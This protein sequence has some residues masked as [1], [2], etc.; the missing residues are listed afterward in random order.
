MPKEI[1]WTLN[2]VPNVVLAQTILYF[3]DKLHELSE[4][5]LLILRGRLSQQS[6]T[7]RGRVALMIVGKALD[8][9]RAAEVANLLLNLRAAAEEAGV[10]V[11]NLPLSQAT[12][13][14]PVPASV[15]LARRTL[16]SYVATEYAYF[17]YYGKQV[18]EQPAY[19]YLVTGNYSGTLVFSIDNYKL[20]A[21]EEAK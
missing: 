9:A 2:I 11:I 5:E 18:D 12:I 17:T 8:T 20:T 3:S 16:G 4:E 6:N 15:E 21:I 1:N 7:R 13:S 14:R 10:E 19:G